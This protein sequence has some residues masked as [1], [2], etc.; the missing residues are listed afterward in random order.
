MKLRMNIN[1]LK[2][3]KAILSDNTSVISLAMSGLKRP[4]RRL[5]IWNSKIEAL[6][7]NRSKK[8]ACKQ[9]K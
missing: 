1:N 8:T 2:I 3:E 5:V 7:G 9:S 6:Q 4:S